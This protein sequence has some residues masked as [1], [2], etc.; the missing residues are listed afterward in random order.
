MT[1]RR[2]T[3]ITLILC[4]GVLGCSW[5]GAPEQHAPGGPFYF[6]ILDAPAVFTDYSMLPRGEIS[7]AEAR[8]RSTW[9]E[10]WFDER[11]RIERMVKCLDGRPGFDLR[12]HYAA[13][14]AFEREEFVAVPE[15]APEGRPSAG[16]CS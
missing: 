3:G 12:Y 11:G 4:T 9:L 15:S 2:A 7:R 1:V 14:G 10:A 5:R 8:T 16:A 6:E 13:D